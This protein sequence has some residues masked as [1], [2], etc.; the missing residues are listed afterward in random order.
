MFL[1]TGDVDGNIQGLVSGS[2]AAG[3]VARLRSCLNNNTIQI[4][5]SCYSYVNAMKQ[6][7]V[8]LGIDKQEQS[9]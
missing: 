9:E 6:N 7:K 1:A 5:T 8:P 4:N 3:M 2:P